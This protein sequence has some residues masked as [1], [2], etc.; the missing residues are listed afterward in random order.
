MIPAENLPPAISR[1]LHIVM[2]GKGGAGKSHVASLLCQ[3]HTEYGQPYQ[4]FDLDPINKTLTAMLPLEV[5]AWKVTRPGESN[6]DIRQLDQLI[7]R[8]QTGECDAILDTGSTS[9]IAFNEYMLKYDIP[10]LLYAADKTHTVL[11][12]VVRAG[13]SLYECIRNLEQL[14]L[15]Y[16]P[17]PSLS[18]VVWLNQVENKI[19]DAGHSYEEMPWYKTH[20]SKISTVVEMEQITDE[21]FRIDVNEMLLRHQTYDEAIQDPATN[22]VSKHRLGILKKNMLRQIETILP[23]GGTDG[24]P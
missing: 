16:H 23:L 7:E 3:Y 12:C 20:Q 13:P 21:M 6:L 24:H 11:H 8:I 22:L 18:I 1:K 9:Y 4:A 2:Q 10:A 19:I 14:L 17:G 5:S 15:S